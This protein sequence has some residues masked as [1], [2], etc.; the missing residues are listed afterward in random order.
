MRRKMGSGLAGL[1]AGIVGISMLLSGC[2]QMTGQADLPPEI[3][4]D[5]KLILYTSHKAEVYGPIVK[6]FEERTGIWVDVHA[7]GTTEMLEAVKASSGKQACD[8]MFGGGVESYEAYRDYLEPYACSQ[9][10]LLDPQYASPE[11]TWTIFTELPIVFIYNN[12]LV[13]EEDAPRSWEEF[14]GDKWKGQIAF[15]DPRKSGTSYT[16]LST[17]IQITGREGSMDIEDTLNQFTEAL[18]G[19]I[20]AGSGE[21]I[22]EIG[23]GFRLVGITLEEAARKEIAAGLDIGMVYPLEGTSAVPDGCALVKGAPHPDN[24]KLFIDFTVS[25][26]VQNLAMDQFCRRTARTDLQRDTENVHALGM[27]EIIPFDLEWAGRHQT[28]LLEQWTKR[29]D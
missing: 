24:A 6:E 12:K 29:I 25:N 15:A 18:D 11:H 26:D 2:G 3:G 20:S 16:A 1:L 5:K 4:E 21:L 8:V 19:N 28:E 7:G 13:S 17:M 9:S 22:K 10:D 27:L 14:L 23:D